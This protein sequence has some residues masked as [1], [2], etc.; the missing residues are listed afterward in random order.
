MFQT[1]E[2]IVVSRKALKLET[3]NIQQVQLKVVAV[4]LL[5]MNLL[6]IPSCR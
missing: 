2:Q 3:G 4:A 6:A 1:P 5:Q